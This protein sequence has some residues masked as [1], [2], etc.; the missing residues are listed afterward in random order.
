VRLTI[1]DECGRWADGGREGDPMLLLA[2][3]WLDY[4]G[5]H[6]PT[7]WLLAWRRTR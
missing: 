5:L 4:L 6:T 1:G 3:A 2:V 7:R